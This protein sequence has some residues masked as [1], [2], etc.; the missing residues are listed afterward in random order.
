MVAA[1]V[2]TEATKPLPINWAA[3]YNNQDK[4][5]LGT[6]VLYQLMDEKLDDKL[7][8]I[9][10]P[11]YERLQD[12]TIQ[13]TYLFIN[14]RIGFDTAELEELMTWVSSGNTVFISANY[15]GQDLLDTLNLEI[16]T[17]F[18]YDRFQSQPMVN[19]VNEKLASER[20]YHIEKDFP[21]R[22]FEEI[23]T[24]S[25]T[26]LGVSQIFN[27]TLKITNPDVNF[28]KAPIG[29]GF[30]Y[31]HT[32]PEIFSNYFLLTDDYATHTKNV[33]SYINDDS[34]VF[35][36]KYYKSGKR[37]NVSP[38]YILFSSKY[39]KWAYYFA[40]IGAVLFV[41]FEGKRK[42]R[43][44]PIVKPQVN[45]TYEYTR[46]ISGMYLDKKE[47]HEIAKKQIS[48]FFEYIRI[49]LRVPTET[50]N[51][52]FLN[53]VAARSEKTLDETKNLITFIEKVQNQHTT[54]KE[55]LLKLNREISEF[56]KNIDGR[57]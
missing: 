32:Q 19:L 2:Y 52:S 57:S 37:I 13:G 38:L 17:G 23:D 21:I 56:K 5:P 6:Y 45:R 36:D 43:S 1:L 44:I 50:I 25:H 16:T 14:D 24:L 3:S 55:E 8:E 49:R 15:L 20:P 31:V 28:I 9:N 27:D 53:A 40:V 22:Y 18:R 11:P 29:N 30:F 54:S 51:S 4:I 42:Q 10:I 47:Y 39:L 12:S 48:L 33:L 35:W 46:V 7:E 26:V 41:F 34:I